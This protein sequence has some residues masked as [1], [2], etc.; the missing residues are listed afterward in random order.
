MRMSMQVFSRSLVLMMVLLAGAP[1][2]EA[3]IVNKGGGNQVLQL[4]QGLISQKEAG[5]LETTLRKM[6]EDHNKDIQGSRSNFNGVNTKQERIDLSGYGKI[7]FDK[8]DDLV[9][10]LRKMIARHNERI[11]KSQ[12]QAQQGSQQELLRQQQEQQRIQWEQQQ[13]MQEQQR[14]Q[15]EQQQRR[16]KEDARKYQEEQQRKLEE[17]QRQL[18]EQKRQLAEQ[19]SELARERERQEK[20]EMQEEQKKNR[21]P[22]GRQE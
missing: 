11:Q 21:K 10:A 13:R 8:R 7:G 4:P 12:K 3:K 1:V 20:R 18:E 19:E 9:K 16:Q 22:R 2:L 15:W 14:I 6:I 5:R 17:Q